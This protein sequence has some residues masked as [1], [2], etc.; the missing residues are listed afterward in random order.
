MNFDINNRFILSSTWIISRIGLHYSNLLFIFSICFWKMIP[1]EQ[2]AVSIK[3]KKFNR[4]KINFSMHKVREHSSSWHSQPSAT[5]TISSMH[6]N[7]NP[8]QHFIMSA[9][10]VLETTDSVS[11]CPLDHNQQTRKPLLTSK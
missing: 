1:E 9:T 8:L 4:T 2:V 10:V 7:I 3:I 6:R 5:H 11:I